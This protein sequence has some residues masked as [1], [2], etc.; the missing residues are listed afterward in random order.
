MGFPF[1]CIHWI[2]LI[3]INSLI[4]CPCRVIIKEVYTL[5]YFLWRTDWPIKL[6]IGTLIRKTVCA[7]VC[8]HTRHFSSREI[9]KCT[10]IY[11]YKALWDKWSLVNCWK[12]IGINLN[13]SIRQWVASSSTMK[14][15]NNNYTSQQAQILQNTDY[16]AGW[17][18][19]NW[20]KEVLYE[21]Y[22][23]QKAKILNLSVLKHL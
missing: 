8:V 11:I 13:V 6:S 5:K 15:T 21:L 18:K 23:L 3:P 9:C 20:K 19:A 10:R 17:K 14:E 4:K 16:R 12:K 2:N 7:C 1:S 22:H